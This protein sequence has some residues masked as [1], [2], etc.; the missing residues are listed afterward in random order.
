M[1]KKLISR[2]ILEVIY[3]VEADFLVKI[4]LG[5]HLVALEGIDGAQYC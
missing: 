1:N 4:L 2:A 5:H 3:P